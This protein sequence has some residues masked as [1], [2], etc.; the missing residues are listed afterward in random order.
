[1]AALFDG[2]KLLAVSVIPSTEG[3]DAHL[4][5]Y[6]I[7]FDETWWT[8]REHLSLRM[9]YDYGDGPVDPTDNKPHSNLPDLRGF[10][11]AKQSSWEV[12]EADIDLGQH[13]VLLF[14]DEE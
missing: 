7:G 6:G 5:D 3:M 1:M 2:R 8:A 9:R 11:R 4:K 12:D 10:W 14:G 13:Q